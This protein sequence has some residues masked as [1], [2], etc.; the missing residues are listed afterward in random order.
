MIRSFEFFMGGAVLLLLSALFG[1]LGYWRFVDDGHV[2][3]VD[4]YNEVNNSTVAPVVTGSVLTVRR[5]AEKLRGPDDCPLLVADHYMISVEDRGRI[6]LERIG[7]AVLAEDEDA[8]LFH[9]DIPKAAANG[10]YVHEA[11]LS[12]QCNPLVTHHYRVTSNEFE[13]A[14]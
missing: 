9:F 5:H 12:Y 8:I 13:L 1:L 3:D 6:F 10:T 7:N 4:R 14:R 11:D 2:F